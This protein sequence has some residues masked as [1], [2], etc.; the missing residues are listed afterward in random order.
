MDDD[1]PPKSPSSDNTKVT[2]AI[3]VSLVAVL[4]VAGIGIAT[5]RDTT[6]NVREVLSSTTTSVAGRGSATPP[7]AS[8]LTPEQARVVEE[9]KGQV[10]AIRGL[11]WKAS[12][13]VRFVTKD[14]LASRVR[15]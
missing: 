7:A 13:P 5:I 1:A 15:Q 6:E 3:L 4:I 8:D 9:M 10:S 14:Q 12:L 2:V 11:E